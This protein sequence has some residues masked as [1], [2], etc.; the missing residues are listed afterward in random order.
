MHSGYIFK[1]NSRV[2]AD[3][4]NEGVKERGKRMSWI[5]TSTKMGKRG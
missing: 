4:L 1:V 2:L 3:R 5:L